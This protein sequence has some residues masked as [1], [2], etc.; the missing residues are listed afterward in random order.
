MIQITPKE[1]RKRERWRE[2]EIFYEFEAVLS[3]CAQNHSNM[4]IKKHQ[5]ALLV[6]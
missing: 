2:R 3:I 1:T 4:R 5:T 6:L